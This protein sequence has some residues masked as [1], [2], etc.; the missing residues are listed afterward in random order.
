MWQSLSF[1][2]NYK[3]AY[4]LS[5][6]PAGEDAFLEERK[7]F[8]ERTVD[9]LRDKAET[10]Y[11]ARGS[12]AEDHVVRRFPNKGVKLVG[13]VLPRATSVRGFLRNLPLAFQRGPSKGLSATYHFTF[14]GREEAKATVVIRE[15]G[16]PDLRMIADSDTWLRFLRKEASL[17]WALLR[18]RCG[19]CSRSLAA[20][21]SK[22]RHADRTHC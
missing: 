21:R 22:H 8:V 13:N 2:P 12:D 15:E 3:A 6:C 18:R 11:V 1:G 7:R 17:P 20:S 5:V 10:I 9:P 16:E 4:C 14:T 19:C